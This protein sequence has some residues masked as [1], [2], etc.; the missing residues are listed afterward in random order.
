MTDP[1]TPPKNMPRVGVLINNYNNGPWLR[2]AVDS[3]L[4]QTRPADEI[5][6]YDDGST[7]DSIATLRGYG[8]RIRLIEGV[9]DDTRSGRAS[10]AAALYHAF[11]TSTAEHLYLLDGDDLFYP[12]KIRSY[13]EA[14]SRCPEAVLV[15]APMLRMD[16]EGQSMEEER[17]AKKHCGD[18]LAATYATQDTDLYYWTSALAFSR[19][20]LGSQLPIDYTTGVDLA[21]DSTLAGVAPL[22]GPVIMLDDIFTVWRRLSKSQKSLLDSTRLTHLRRRHTNFNRRAGSLGRPKIHLLLNREFY[23]ECLRALGG[24]YVYRLFCGR[25]HGLEKKPPTPCP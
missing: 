9:H 12:D 22:Y 13:E 3:V 7:D 10:Q 14:W 19:K 5:I 17:E 23:K 8:D 24:A 21:V 20:F 25:P 2:A 18:Y 16:S 4:A 15:N 6:A 11:S 1:F